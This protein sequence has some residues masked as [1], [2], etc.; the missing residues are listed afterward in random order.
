MWGGFLAGWPG[1]PGNAG[2]GLAC[3]TL[4]SIVIHHGCIVVTGNEYHE[5][6]KSRLAF[7]LGLALRFPPSV[8]FAMIVRIRIKTISAV[9]V[10]HRNHYA[11]CIVCITYVQFFSM[12]FTLVCTVCITYVQ[13]FSMRFT[14]EYGPA[15][16]RSVASPLF[17]EELSEIPGRGLDYARGGDVYVDGDLAAKREVS[18]CVYS[19]EY[20]AENELA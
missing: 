10:T 16:F 13:F 14:L 18:S 5:D 11:V 20:V 3:Y 12:R 2:V 4:F 17:A 8:L 19:C 1:L 7:A 9:V 15:L 6:W